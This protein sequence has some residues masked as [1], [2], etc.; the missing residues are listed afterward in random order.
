MRKNTVR[1]NRDNEF[2]IPTLFLVLAPA[3]NPGVG[4]ARKNCHSDSACPE[5]TYHLICDM[6]KADFDGACQRGAAE[7]V[8]I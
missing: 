5:L 7:K 8:I 1:L 2:C 3:I 4:S 6:I